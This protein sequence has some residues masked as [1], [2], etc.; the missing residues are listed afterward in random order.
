[1]SGHLEIMDKITACPPGQRM[2]LAGDG[3][4]FQ[5]LAGHL[6]PHC[7]VDVVFGWR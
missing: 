1:M 4:I 7:A 5:S 6:R 2:V 3:F